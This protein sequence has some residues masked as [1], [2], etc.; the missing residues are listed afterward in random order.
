MAKNSIDLLPLIVV[1]VTRATGLSLLVRFVP[2]AASPLYDTPVCVRMTLSL[3]CRRRSLSTSF[4]SSFM[5]IICCPFS[6]MILLRLLRLL[7]SNSCPVHI[8][9]GS[10]SLGTNRVKKLYTLRRCYCLFFL[11]YSFI[12]YET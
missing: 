1:V 12:F 3:F 10:R 5:I 2:C 11:Y 6:F 9:L 7:W 8:P 4:S